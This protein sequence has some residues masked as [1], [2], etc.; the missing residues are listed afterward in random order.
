MFDNVYNPEYSNMLTRTAAQRAGPVLSINDV[1]G[2]HG[3]LQSH[4]KRS[5]AR[6][7]VCKNRATSILCGCGARVCN[8]LY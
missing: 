3:T 6:C 4:P 1:L 5:S 8:P 2:G 7:V